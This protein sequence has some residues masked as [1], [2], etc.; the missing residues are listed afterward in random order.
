MATEGLLRGNC[1]AVQYQGQGLH[2][3]LACVMGQQMTASFLGSLSQGSCASETHSCL[4]P[5]GPALGSG[6]GSFAV[7]WRL[8]MLL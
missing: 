1:S 5:E 2:Q 7:G 6:C 3:E 8:S 4:K